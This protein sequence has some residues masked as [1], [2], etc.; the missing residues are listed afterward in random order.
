L[1][2]GLGYKKLN[3]ARENKQTLESLTHKRR[4]RLATVRPANGA[5]WFVDIEDLAK[6]LDRR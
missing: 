1:G 6:K 3:P 4:P 5:A 2:T